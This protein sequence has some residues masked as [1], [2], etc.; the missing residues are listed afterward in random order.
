MRYNTPSHVHK[1]LAESL[2]LSRFNYYNILFDNILLLSRFNYYDIL[3]DNILTYVKNQLPKLKMQQLRA[4][5]FNKYA[6]IK[7]VIELKWLTS[8]ERME[9]S[10]LIF[11]FKALYN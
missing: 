1:Q 8:E 7:D 5:F 10:K 6:K 11:S 2:L 4:F 3:F 9:L